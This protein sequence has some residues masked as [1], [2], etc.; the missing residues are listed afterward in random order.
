VPE[1]DRLSKALNAASADIWAE[2]HNAV[3]TQDPVYALGKNVT[4]NPETAAKLA[5]P[6]FT[7]QE[8]KTLAHDFGRM[9]R[10][11][12]LLATGDL[13]PAMQE[14]LQA[15]YNYFLNKY[16]TVTPPSTPTTGPTTATTG[17]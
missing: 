4:L 3:G 12:R 15:R 11:K 13:P 8:A 6:N 5:N 17:Q 2:K 10:L 9:L 7:P 14:R 1:A 16:F